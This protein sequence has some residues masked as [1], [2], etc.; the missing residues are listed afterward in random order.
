M[1]LFSRLFRRKPEYIYGTAGND[2]RLARRHKSGRVEF[3]MWKAGEQG[4]ERDYWI[5]FHE[6]WWPTFKEGGQHGTDET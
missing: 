6:Y 2:R 4:H 1:G 5:A 3:V